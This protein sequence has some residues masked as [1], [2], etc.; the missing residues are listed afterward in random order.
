MKS[1]ILIAF[2]LFNSLLFSDL[3]QKGYATDFSTLDQTVKSAS[4]KVPKLALYYQNLVTGQ[5][6]SYQSTNVF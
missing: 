3:P 6:Y 4:K 2:I 5:S 1:K